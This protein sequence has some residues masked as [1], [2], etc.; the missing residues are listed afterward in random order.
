MNTPI[1]VVVVIGAG[2]TGLSISYHLKKQNL[3]YIVF[4]QGKIGNSCRNQR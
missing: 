1:L 3:D 4:E 2:H